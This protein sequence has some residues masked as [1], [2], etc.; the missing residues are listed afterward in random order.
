MEPAARGRHSCQ[1]H[2]AREKGKESHWTLPF[3]PSNHPLISKHCCHWMNTDRSQLMP[4]LRTTAYSDQPSVIRG[5]QGTTKDDSDDK[6]VQGQ[7]YKHK[8]QTHMYVLTS[9]LAQISLLFSSKDSFTSSVT[10]FFNSST[11]FKYLARLLVLKI[12]S[13]S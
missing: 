10:L 5:R 7:I 12:I 3:P 1:R 2:C 8:L 4:G 13:A 11:A 6:Q 9:H